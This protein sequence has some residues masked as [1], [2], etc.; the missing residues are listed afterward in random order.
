MVIGSYILIITLNVNGL[1]APIKRHMAVWMK[2]V[3]ECTFT[4]HITLLNPQI[5]LFYIVRLIMLIMSP[6]WHATVIIFFFFLVW[7]LIVK[8]NKHLL[9]L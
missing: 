9:L 2:H 4:Y 6:L 1:N 3:H 7:L 5:V 8:T